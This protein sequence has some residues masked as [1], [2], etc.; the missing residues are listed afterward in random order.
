MFI[1]FFHNLQSLIVFIQQ[2][3]IIFGK[4]YAAAVY[5]CTLC[6]KMFSIRGM[7]AHKLW[8]CMFMIQHNNI[9]CIM[10]IPSDT[11]QMAR[12]TFTLLKTFDVKL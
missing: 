12:Q 9:K 5:V 7:A 2:I 4:I 10:C 1:M 6:R 3:K 11:E 8:C